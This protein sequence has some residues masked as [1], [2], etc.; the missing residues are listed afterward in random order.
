M[1][2]TFESTFFDNDMVSNTILFFFT[3]ISFQ[4][5]CYIW[6]SILF[7]MRSVSKLSNT[8]IWNS[9]Y[10]KTKVTPVKH[11]RLLFL[12]CEHW[13]IVL[14]SML[15][16]LIYLLVLKTMYLLHFY[17]FC[18]KVTKLMLCIFTIS[19]VNSLFF[20]RQMTIMCTPMYPVDPKPECNSLNVHVYYVHSSTLLS[21]KLC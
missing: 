11:K 17:R 1:Y 18:F 9:N 16:Q 7:H 21:L 14:K 3:W 15:K 20:G 10:R 12:I 19:A 2:K 6:D 13:I 4:I 8:Q 5:M